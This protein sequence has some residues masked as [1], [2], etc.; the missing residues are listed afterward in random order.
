MRGRLI[1]ALVLEAGL[2]QAEVIDRVAASVGRQA[3]TESDVDREIRLAAFL[4]RTQPDF[5]APSKRRAAERLVDRALMASELALGQYSLPNPAEAGPALESLKKA[6]FPTEAA[7]Q[8]ALAGYKIGEETLRSFLLDQL[9]VVRF[10][11]SR[12]GA[13][14]QVI[15]SQMRGYYTSRFLPQWENKK[16]NGPPPSFDEVRGEIEEIV[17]QEE[18]DRLLDNWLKEA[19]GRIRI[20]FKEEALR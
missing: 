11:S 8:E 3:I 13:G 14:A 10:I 20:E 12:F 19:K 16:S 18:A 4:N 9:R 1:L 6:R 15:E 7:F 5:T 2:C 17:R